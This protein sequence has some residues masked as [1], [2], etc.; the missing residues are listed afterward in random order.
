MSYDL[1]ITKAEN[2]WQSEE[3]PI[4]REEIMSLLSSEINF[5]I[6]SQMVIRNPLNGDE[7]C[8]PG[9]YIVWQK[10]GEELWFRYTGNRII[11]QGHCDEDIE[12]LKHIAGILNA[13]VQG[14]E[15]EIY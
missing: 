6:K 2:W 9:E 14:D 1:H 5:S 11:G 3:N 7:I 13:K 8:I 10:D 4:K 15:G 12:N